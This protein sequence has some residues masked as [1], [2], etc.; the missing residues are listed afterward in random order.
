MIQIGVDSVTNFVYEARRAKSFYQLWPQPL[1]SVAVLC[2]L[3]A[4]LPSIEDDLQRAGLIFREDSFDPVTRI[5]RG[6]FYSASKD[7][8]PSTENRHRDHFHNILPAMAQGEL[9]LFLFDQYQVTDKRALSRKVAAIGS[10]D[11]LWRILTVER[12]TTAEL[13]VT[14]KARHSLGVLPEL[15]SP[16]IPERGRAKAVE[17]YEKLSDAAY[18]ESPVAIVD[19][20]RDAAQWFLATAAVNE[21]GDD[22]WLHRDLASLIRRLDDKNSGKGPKV[23]ASAAHII[24]RLH[25]RAKPNEQERLSTRPL[26]ESDAEFA[27][28][29]VGLILREF[30]WIP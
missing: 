15:A 16:K 13:L 27:L 26:M 11:S 6:R 9:S 29:G 3:G 12:I 18:R 19:R 30:G 4:K 21:T 23:L 14:L 2:S 1:L 10:S 7:P 5:R 25:S 24:A 22:S 28:A 17:T 20:A 8:R